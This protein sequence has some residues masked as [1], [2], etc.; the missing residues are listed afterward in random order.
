MHCV[1][2]DIK[3]LYK[4]ISGQGIEIE[5]RIFYIV[6]NTQKLFLITQITKLSHVEDSIK[7]YC[8][9][10]RECKSSL[11]N[12]FEQL[13]SFDSQIPTPIL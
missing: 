8:E 3:W 13:P 4:N 1:W 12:Q 11:M 5:N 2:S 6:D 10:I 9:N 7:M